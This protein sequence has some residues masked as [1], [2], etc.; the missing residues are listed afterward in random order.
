MSL[1][2]RPPPRTVAIFFG[3]VVMAVGGLMG[4]LC[5]ACTLIVWG[6]GFTSTPLDGAMSLFLTAA[7]I[8]GL[9]TVCGAALFWVGWRMVRPRRTTPRPAPETFD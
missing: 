7:V 4:L 3:W 2:D 5:G 8:G 1:Y 6:V 9:P